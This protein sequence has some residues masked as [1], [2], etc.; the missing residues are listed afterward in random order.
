MTLE[1]LSNLSCIVSLHLDVEAVGML[2]HES[3]VT[4]S[5]RVN[6]L[7]PCVIGMYKD[8]VFSMTYIFIRFHGA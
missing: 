7:V 6:E 1:D 8:V 4:A 2:E 5:G 3:V